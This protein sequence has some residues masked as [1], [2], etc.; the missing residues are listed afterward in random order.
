VEL[1]WKTIKIAA[2]RNGFIIDCDGEVSVAT[3]AQL[4]K[5]IASVVHDDGMAPMDDPGQLPVEGERTRNRP[6]PDRRPIELTPEVMET[7]SRK[8]ENRGFT[9][10]DLSD[11]FPNSIG[12]YKRASTLMRKGVDGGQFLPGARTKAGVLHQLA[13]EHETIRKADPAPGDAMET[14]E[15]EP[16]ELAAV[17]AEGAEEPAAEVDTESPE[18]LFPEEP[19]TD[20]PPPAEEPAGPPADESW[21][22]P[23]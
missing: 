5:H 17:A 22:G 16:E 21:D 8:S 10:S 12:T 13:P 2:V 6:A 3:G 14:E 4:A 7:I 1:D 11:W 20:E 23:F 9:I 18:E 19:D 15:A